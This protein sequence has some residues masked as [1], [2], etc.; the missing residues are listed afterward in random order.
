MSKEQP[1]A[2]KAH[3]A[4]TP[5]PMVQAAESAVAEA[6]FADLAQVQRAADEPQKATP[7][8]LRGVQRAYGNQFVQRAVN[9]KGRK[10]G[11][12]PIQ[13]KL[14][15]NEPDDVY[16][17]EAERVAEALPT[18]SVA[19]SPAPPNGNGNE[20]TAKAATTNVSA[21]VPSPPSPVP[22]PQLAPLAEQEAE[23]VADAVGQAHSAV[24]PVGGDEGGGEGN[25]NN[26]NG[27]QRTSS[28]QSLVPSPLSPTTPRH[29]SARR[30]QP[31]T[32]GTV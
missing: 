1:N 23:V 14:T 24:P 25:N 22:S 16:E 12:Q 28:P 10:N 2:Q 3:D 30:A 32:R 20:I 7:R 8:A 13:T 6:D 15:V 11:R 19:T 29:H 27:L 4:K 26:S 9:G 5:K 18:N 31:A 17:Q 21:A